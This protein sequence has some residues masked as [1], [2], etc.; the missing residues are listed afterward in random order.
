MIAAEK[1]GA[2]VPT[3]EDNVS[4]VLGVVLPAVGARGAVPPPDEPTTTT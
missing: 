2:S 4:I 1:S 3:S